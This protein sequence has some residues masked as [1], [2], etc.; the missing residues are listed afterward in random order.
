MARRIVAGAV[1]R[2]VCV[3]LDRRAFFRP[4][5]HVF[6]ATALVLRRSL[7]FFGVAMLRFLGLVARR[8]P[9]R[10]ICLVRRIVGGA[11]R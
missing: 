6:A 8:R 3:T 11:T 2:L 7:V 9:R 10:C 1:A 5:L 4:A